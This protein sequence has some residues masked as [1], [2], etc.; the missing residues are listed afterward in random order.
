MKH[1]WIF[2]CVAAF[3]G[4]RSNAVYLGKRNPSP[5]VIGFP[6]HKHTGSA[7]SPRDALHRRASS[8]TLTQGLKFQVK[9]TSRSFECCED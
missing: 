6:V 7:S 3:L 5:A 8:K 2:T 1:F 9:C 4:C